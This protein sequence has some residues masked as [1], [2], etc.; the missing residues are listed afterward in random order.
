[1]LFPPDTKRYSYFLDSKLPIS[2]S[3]EKFFGVTDLPPPP[4]PPFILAQKY[5]SRR[6]KRGESEK[7]VFLEAF[8]AFLGPE[9]FVDRVEMGG[10]CTNRAG[11]PTS[12][13]CIASH[14]SPNAVNIMWQLVVFMFLVLVRTYVISNP[15]IAWLSET[16]FRLEWRMFMTFLRRTACGVLLIKLSGSYFCIPWIVHD[17]GECFASHRF[18]TWA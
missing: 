14:L 16:Y 6:L 15:Q 13:L 12:F 11:L 2:N 9:F 8:W 3:L 5:G 1:M 17:Q 18:G 7:H 4:P 10:G